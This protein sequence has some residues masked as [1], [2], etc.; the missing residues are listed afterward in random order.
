MDT[1]S[2]A[3]VKKQAKEFLDRVAEM[4]IKLKDDKEAFYGC[5]ESS[6]LRRSSMDLTRALAQLR[7]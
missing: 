2:L 7:R 5:P 6:A 4:E 3:R 1:I